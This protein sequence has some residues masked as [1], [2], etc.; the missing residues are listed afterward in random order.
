MGLQLDIYSHTYIPTVI[1]IWRWQ[2]YNL[3]EKQKKINIAIMGWFDL[4]DSIYACD[5]WTY[6]VLE[7][8]KKP[9]KQQ[10][11]YLFDYIWEIQTIFWTVAYTLIFLMSF[12]RKSY[13]VYSRY[14]FDA[15]ATNIVWHILRKIKK[16]NNQKFD[17]L[18]LNTHH[19]HCDAFEFVWLSYLYN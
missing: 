3:N 12:L 2:T 16:K 11:R 19:N 9:K 14:I 13:S 4:I 10:Q 5:I 15:L 6:F 7:W 8:N 18:L 1:H 17:N